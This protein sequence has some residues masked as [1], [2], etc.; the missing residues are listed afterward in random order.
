MLYS[1]WDE[2][3]CLDN[4]LVWMHFYYEDDY[5]KSFDLLVF[6]LIIILFLVLFWESK[7]IYLFSFG[8]FSNFLLLIKIS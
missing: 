8:V 2:E 7:I 5:V 1:L 4:D 6:A 3:N